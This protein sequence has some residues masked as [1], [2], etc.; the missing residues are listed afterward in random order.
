MRGSGKGGSSGKGV[1]PIDSIQLFH[2][3]FYLPSYFHLV[4]QYSYTNIYLK[5]LC[6]ELT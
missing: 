4:L 1:T 6:I 5:A 2:P 3:A